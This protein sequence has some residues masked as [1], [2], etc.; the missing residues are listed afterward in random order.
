MYSF[1][2]LARDSRIGGAGPGEGNLIAHNSGDA[3]AVN[4]S[5]GV[6]PTGVRVSRNSIFA[7]GEL[8]INLGTVFAGYPATVSL[9]DLGDVD[10]GP[11]N[12]QN[13]PVLSSAV[14]N[15]V[16]TTVAGTIDMPSPASAT[17]E[18][19]SNDA[20]DPS[21]FGEG[22]SF[23]ASTTPSPTG[24]FVASL[25]AG[26][27]GKYLTA[28]ATDA[29]GNTS[30]FCAGII[31]QLR[32]TAVDPTAGREAR[33]MDV[34]PN[35]ARAVASVRLSLPGPE[36]ASVAVFDLS[37][38]RVR[39]LVERRLFTPGLHELQWRGDDERG[40]P[41]PQGL[42]FLRFDGAAGLKVLKLL[43]TR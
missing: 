19:Y 17:I 32:T 12:L 21:G 18:I 4:S 16:A 1:L 38:R 29:G 40:T 33:W 31:V 7:N 11:N 14:D 37:G 41:V 36:L 3:V 22:E 43:L 35:P 39:T 26:L 30:E 28:T 2:D 13:F 5:A 10:A 24:D 6:G 34:R 25:P 15:G 20:L 9:N 27:A 8:G 42:Y 23:A